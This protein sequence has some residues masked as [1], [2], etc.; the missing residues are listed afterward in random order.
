MPSSSIAG[1]LDHEGALASLSD[2]QREA[3]AEL[4]EFRSYRAG[5]CVVKSGEVL[6]GLYVLVSGR[7]RVVDDRR[8]AASVP[9]DVLSEGSC[10]GEAGLF[11]EEASDFSV[12]AESDVAAYFVPSRGFRQLCATRK[13]IERALERQKAGRAI[14]DFLKSSTVFSVLSAAQLEHL[15]ASMDCRR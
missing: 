15:A 6:E 11:A 10:F 7:L 12:V 4:G 1:F 8:Q 3:I 13:D 5:D 14:R 9:L 2:E